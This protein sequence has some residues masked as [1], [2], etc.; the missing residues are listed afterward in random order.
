MPKE[1]RERFTP[2][3][4]KVGNYTD[5]IEISRDSPDEI[6]EV[7]YIDDWT[8]EQEALANAY[9]IHAAPR[10][11]KALASLAVIIHDAEL[12]N[13]LASARGEIKDND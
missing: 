7:C 10:M 12:D 4:W 9:L 5:F 1:R 6:K 2:G 11:Y 8:D 13:L 3:P